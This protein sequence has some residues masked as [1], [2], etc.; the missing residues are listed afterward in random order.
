MINRS[1][2]SGGT[3][4][5]DR[6]NQLIILS[7]LPVNTNNKA[8]D[9]SGFIKK[10]DSS[11]I[12]IGGASFRY[13]LEIFG[14]AISITWAFA[15]VA[16]LIMYMTNTS[17]N[18][19]YLL[20]F[21]IFLFTISLPLFFII[22]ITWNAH[23]K[24]IKS[25]YLRFNRQRREVALPFGESD[26][27]FTIIP[28]EHIYAWVGTSRTLT[29]EM[30]HVQS[31]LTITMA[32]RSDPQG[33]TGRYEIMCGDELNCIM[34][35]ECIRCFMEDGPDACPDPSNLDT[36]E[37][38][39]DSRRRWKE[40]KVLE[41]W[42]YWKQRIS[43]WLHWSYFAH[44]FSDWQQTKLQDVIPAEIK[45]WSQ[46]IPEEQRAKPSAEL[47]EANTTVEVYYQQGC[48]CQLK[49]SAVCQFKMSGF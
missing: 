13:A 38:Y 16:I 30:T 42:E 43:D 7:P 3:T 15:V 25:P 21:A 6:L 46:P 27:R 45:Q 1:E 18:I 10:K 23:R 17:S 40:K 4:F 33:F 26:T 24:L 44:W 35:W 11:N 22:P 34:Q 14:M 20:Y 31:S 49:K 28:W 48:Q 29:D 47:V 8:I 37:E 19:N 2:M 9:T 41:G 36:L 5:K 12:D 32:S 39:I